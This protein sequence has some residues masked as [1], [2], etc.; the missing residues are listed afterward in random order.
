MVQ[1]KC[2]TLHRNWGDARK[3]F[4]FEV[5]GSNLALEWPMVRFENDRLDRI[6]NS[7]RYL[8]R[9]VN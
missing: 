4:P 6:D 9:T 8:I 7:S 1:R 3:V 2:G 5:S